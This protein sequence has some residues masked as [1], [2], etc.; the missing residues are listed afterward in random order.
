MCLMYGLLEALPKKVV[1]WD[2]LVQ[3]DNLFFLRQMT[4]LKY[5]ED[6]VR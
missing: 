4:F 2:I 3:T 1:E 5:S 6:C